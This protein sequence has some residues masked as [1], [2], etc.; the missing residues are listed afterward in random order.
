[1]STSTLQDSDRAADEQVLDGQ[2]A[3][4]QVAGEQAADEQVVEDQSAVAEQSPAADASIKT[5]SIKAEQLHRIAELREI[6][7]QKKQELD[8]AK[9]DAKTCRQDYER[10]W[11]NLGQYID[12]CNRELPLFDGDKKSG[13]AADSADAAASDA[14]DDAWRDASI[15]ELGLPPKMTEKLREHNVETIGQLEDLR[16]GAGLNSVKGFGEAKITQIEDAVVGWLSKNRDQAALAAARN[17]EAVDGEA[18]AEAVIEA[19]ASQEVA[20]DAEA[21]GDEDGGDVD[22]DGI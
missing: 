18:E 19:E 8:A 10:A 12:E 1:M 17:G 4:G 13:D 16:A 11:A 9:E 22:L 14:N 2:V 21:D 7:K 15:D 20:E 5:E 6:V 3:D